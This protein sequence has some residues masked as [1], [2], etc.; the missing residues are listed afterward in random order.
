MIEVRD[1]GFGVKKDDIPF[2]ALPHCTSKISSFCDLCT[3]ETYGFRGEALH[4][5]T[6]M[7]SLSITSR[8]EEDDVATMCVFNSSGHV[9]CTKAS[10]L[11][12]GTTVCITD[13]FKDFPVRRQ[14]YKSPK[15]CKVGLKRV[16][17]YLYAFGICHPDVRFQLSHNTLTLWQKLWAPNFEVNAMNIL[18]PVLF[19]QMSPLNYQCFDPMVKIQALVPKPH[20]DVS[21]LTRSTPDKIHL[22]INKRPV[23]IKPLVQVHTYNHAFVFL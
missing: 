8:T 9:V 11:A 12:R 2:M 14:H 20:G 3:L 4:S 21:N 1:N 7:G 5:M 18:G 6:G 17:N 23:I 15:H 22:L 13:L 16:E 19:H 10:H